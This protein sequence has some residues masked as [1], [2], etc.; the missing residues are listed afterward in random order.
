M[1]VKPQRPFRAATVADDANVVFYHG[2][3]Y[4]FN[5][6][7]AL[8]RSFVLAAAFSPDGNTLVTV[9]AGK[10]IQL[11]DGKT[12]QPTHQVGQG[13]HTGTIFAVSWSQDSKTFATASADQTV[14]LWDADAR[15]LQTWKFGDG[16]SVGHQ[17]VGVVVPHGRSDGLIISLSLDGDLTYLAR[18]KPQPFRILQGHTKAIT[19]MA[20]SSD[21]QVWTGSFDGRV[22]SWDVDSGTAT[23]V[24]GEPHN[25][26]VVEL[27]ARSNHVY[28]ASW[29]DMIKTADVSAKTFL[30][31]P[32][33]L[34]SQ[35]KGASA[36]ADGVLYVATVSGVAAYADG[37]LLKETPLDAAPGAIAASG[38]LV[39]VGADQGSLRIYRADSAG[40]LD[41]VKALALP[42]GAITALAFSNDGRHL[43]AGN[44]VGKVYVYESSTW[45]LVTDRWSA[46]TARVTSISW[47][48]SGAYAASGSL[49]T[50]IF[51]WCLDKKNQGKRIKAANAHKDGVSGICWVRGG[52]LAS[53][54]VDATVKL[55]DV[56]NLP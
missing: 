38:P 12:G 25:N 31:Q 9:G 28:S 2:A 20:V 55:W 51:V 42:T 17:Q 47:H 7:T 26:Q 44:S 46:H 54:G 41:Q 37:K 43:A 22:C 52:K 36:S 53:A 4:K 5:H 48:D 29:D 10:T 11:Y 30:G 3:P 6:K 50:N 40:N 35:P 1:A 23:L 16:V 34:P 27:T 13:E 45:D 8:H 19:A 56:R 49:D 24:D 21:G 39:A 18:G 32:I 15:T 14:R 33:K